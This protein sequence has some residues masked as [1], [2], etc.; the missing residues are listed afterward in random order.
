M[1]RENVLD[2][3]KTC[4]KSL[5][6]ISASLQTDDVG[7]VL[8]SFRPVYEHP[9][10]QK[11]IE[12]TKDVAEKVDS[13]CKET[14]QKVIFHHCEIHIR[15][16]FIFYSRIWRLIKSSRVMIQNSVKYMDYSHVMQITMYYVISIIIN[17]ILIINNKYLNSN[18]FSVSLFNHLLL[19]E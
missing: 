16:F 11:G 3:V 2:F 8:E 17:Q 18:L 9:V 5:L 19:L 6:E 7:S 15:C 10:M 1:T 14:T 12:C 13:Y 4:A